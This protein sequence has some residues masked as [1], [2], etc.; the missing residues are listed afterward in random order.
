[1][2]AA[3][4][5][6]KLLNDRLAEKDEVIKA[7]DGTIAVKDEMIG[8][9]KSATSDRKQ[10]GNIDDLRLAD[11]H[12]QLAKADAR[13]HQLEHPGFFRTLFDVKTLSGAGLGY[14]GCK[15]T[16]SFGK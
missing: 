9:L 8:L 16:N 2:K 12:E 1:M 7:K 11:A 13:I 6:E 3:E 15:A 14:I 5:R 4:E 10:A